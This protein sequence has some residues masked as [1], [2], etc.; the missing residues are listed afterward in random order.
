MQL[1]KLTRGE[2]FDEGVSAEEQM[3][4]AAASEAKDIEEVVA[5]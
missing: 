4:Q 3:A 1:S 5:E 2:S